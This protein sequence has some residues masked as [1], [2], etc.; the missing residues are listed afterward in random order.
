MYKFLT[1]LLFFI[2]SY[3]NLAVTEKYGTSDLRN[4]KISTRCKYQIKENAVSNKYEV[5]VWKNF[6]EAAISHTWDDN[7]SNQL[8]VALPIYDHYNFKTTFFTVSGWEPNWES[9][10]SAMLNG[11]EVASHSHSHRRFDELTKKEINSELVNSKNEIATKLGS[12][13]CLTYAY[14]NCIT[15]DYELTKNF[16]IAARDCD[17]QIE[18]QTPADFMKISSFLCGSESENKTAKH[19]NDIAE[20]AAVEKGWA[21]YLFHGVDN[22]GGYSS[23]KSD[24]LAKHLKFLDANRTT[25]W[26]DT[27]VNVVKYI[28]ERDAVIVKELSNSRNIITAELTDGLDNDIYNYPL[29]IKKEIPLYWNTVKVA[30]N[31]KAVQFFIKKEDGKQYVIFEA[32]PDAGIVSIKNYK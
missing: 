22:D 30:Q 29:S 5:A 7:T 8:T 2:F 17:E 3:I 25:Y 31:K 19:F 27:F 15:E 1:V 6:T 20:S 12:N 18:A 26:L 24:E 4:Y 32:I 21:V 28:K 9:L 14:S 13:K 23:I 16:Y 11:H 10:R